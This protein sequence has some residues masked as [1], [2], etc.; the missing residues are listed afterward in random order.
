MATITSTQS[1]DWHVTSTWVGGEVPAADDLVVV[2]HGHRVTLSTDITS[3]RTGDVTIDGNLHFATG[4]KMHLHGRMTVKNTS[5]DNSTAGEFVNGSSSSGSLLSMANGT[6][7]KIS[8]DNSAQHGIQVDSRRWCG[9]QIDG[10]EPTLKT[11]LNGNHDYESTYLTVDNS[12]NFAAGDLI[13]IY[14]REEDYSCLLY[15]SD[16]AD[17]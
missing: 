7:I 6:E 15:T 9:V 5:N 1:G 8:G 11:E 14:R 17:E 3:T 16:A 4:G 13:S 10:G 12:A 2:A